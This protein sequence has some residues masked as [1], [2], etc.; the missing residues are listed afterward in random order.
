[1]FFAPGAG[2]SLGHLSFA[3]FTLGMAQGGEAVG[4]AFPG[5]D[6]PDD[7]QAGVT[8]R[9]RDGLIEA[10]IHVN[11]GLLHM[12]HVGRTVLDQTSA[13]TQQGAQGN[14]VGLGTEGGGEQAE[15]VEGL[16]PLTIEDIRFVP[17]GKSAGHMAADETAVDAVVFEDLEEG[18]PVDAGGFH[19]DSLDAVFDQPLGEGV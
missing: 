4:V 7:A 14:Q 18:D 9:V 6:G 19:G 12:E 17:R 1:M 11:E 16:D 2:E 13:V 15:G 5:D 8:G 10:D 3:L